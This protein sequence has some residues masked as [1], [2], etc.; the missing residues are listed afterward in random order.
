MGRKETGES[1]E[2]EIARRREREHCVENR[3]HGEMMCL[4][5]SHLATE[6]YFSWEEAARGGKKEKL[7]GR[8]ADK[9][10]SCG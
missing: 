9:D 8:E 4:H 6:P 7:E 5:M 3:I 1:E 10:L 2:M